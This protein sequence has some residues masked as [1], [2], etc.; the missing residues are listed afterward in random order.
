MSCPKI[1]LYNGSEIPQM[2]FGVYQ[3]K[4]DELTEKCVSEALKVGY[5]HID[6]AHYYENERGVG[7]AIKKSG[8]PRNEI[9]VTSKV[10]VTEFGK[11]K[12]TAAIEKML[13]R[14]DMEYIDL[15]LIHYPYNDYLGAYKELEEEY[16]KGHIKNIGISN[17]EDS[18]FEDL[19]NKVEIKPVLNQI[20]LHPYFQQRDIRKRMNDLNVKTEGWAPLGQASSNLFNEDAIKKLA[21]KYKKTAA[22]I[23]LRWHIQSGFITIPKSCK[24]E[25]IKEN[26][27]VFDF[28]LTEDEMKSI[29]ALNGKR[30]RVQYNSFIMY[31]GLWL[32]PAPKD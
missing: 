9:W 2:G 16:K 21:E 26:F 22:Q 20:E 8:I 14:L 12:T 24:P 19:Y 29:D 32:L 1:K 13:K 11:G 5:R 23:I 28:E 30:G 31:F 3:I 15:V 4:G 27:E 7:A 17:F 10:W 25:R 6:T 18:K